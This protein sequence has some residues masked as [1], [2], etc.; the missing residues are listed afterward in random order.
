MLAGL[1]VARQPRRW[2]GWCRPSEADREGEG[3]GDGG[4]DGVVMKEEEVV[5]L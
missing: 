1:G 5:E 4:G 3:V 2:P